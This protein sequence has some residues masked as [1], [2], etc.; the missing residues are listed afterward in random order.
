M[1]NGPHLLFVY[2]TLKRGGPNHHLLAAQRYVAPARTVPGHTLY[3][4]GEYPGLVADP[5]DA[6]GVAGELWS[7]SSACLAALDRF[8]GVPEG[9]YR[10]QRL[11]LRP[12]HHLLEVDTYVYL[13][14]V[15]DYPR[16]GPHWPI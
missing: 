7:V 14:P 2:G 8:E 9:L 15:S 10:R 6:E 1:P 5:A 4:L 12:P 3:H 16:L 11:P 13:L